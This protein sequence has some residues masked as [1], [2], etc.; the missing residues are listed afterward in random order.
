M[1]ADPIDE[2]SERAEQAVQQGIINARA[3]RRQPTGFCFNCGEDIAAELIYCD[4]DCG[5]DH[6]RREKFNR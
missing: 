4:A 3:A 5:S 2:A 1:Y 6:E